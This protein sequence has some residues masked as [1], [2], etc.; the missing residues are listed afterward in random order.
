MKNFLRKFRPTT[1]EDI[2]AALALFRPGPMNNIDS[3][4]KRKHGKEKIDYLHP[5]L[6]KILENTYGIIIYQEQIMSIANILAGYS[7]GEADIL[8]RA[9]SKKKEE[10]LLQEKDKFIKRSVERGY[11]LDIATKIYDLILKFA[12]YGFNRAHSVAYAM[13]SYRMAYLKAHYPLYF[14]KQLL[15]MHIGSIKTKEYIYECKL[16]NIDILKPDINKSGTEYIAEKNGIR[17][18]LT[19]IKN[20]GVNVVNFI[21]TEREKG[22]FTS[23]YDFIKRTYG[24]TVNSKT[25]QIIKNEKTLF[26]IISKFRQNLIKNLFKIFDKNYASFLSGLLIGDK[27]NIEDEMSESFRNSSLSHVLAISGMHVVY[28]INRS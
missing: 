3:Y 8:R 19:G 15:N 21:I 10:L 9:M 5:D 20:L 25:V 4:I 1:F 24:K 17:F 13:I 28:I 18:P 22:E 23:I 27:S 12:D 6:K 7:L 14:M 11:T 16:N 26:S 2:F